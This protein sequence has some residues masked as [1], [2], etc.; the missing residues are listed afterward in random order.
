M[1]AETVEP[2]ESETVHQITSVPEPAA[3][4]APV[5]EGPTLEERMQLLGERVEALG[6]KIAFDSEWKK[7]LAD[8]RA[9]VFDLAMEVR[10]A[11]GGSV[12]SFA[13]TFGPKAK[14]TFTLKESDD[15]IVLDR[16]EEF[17]D[18]VMDNHPSEVDT[19]I[20][21]QPAFQTALLK[22]AIAVEV[23]GEDGT[24]T[25]QIIDPETG[26]II[27]GLRLKKGTEPTSLGTSWA[28]EGKAL[29]LQSVLGGPLETLLGIEAGEQQ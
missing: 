8:E 2:D 20:I 28:G 7:H 19:K 4:V 24:K 14:V 6:K 10:A 27:A 16:A 3:T 12:K 1:S 25:T 22:R 17:E 11:T 21:V 5:E 29:A 9:E 18:W 13:H 15:S 23:E 26:S